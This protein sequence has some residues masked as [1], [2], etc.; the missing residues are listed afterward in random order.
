MSDNQNESNEPVQSFPDPTQQAQV[1]VEPQV[2]VEASGE[3]TA[4]TQEIPTPTVAEASVTPAPTVEP[5][6][7]G[8]IPAGPT[9]S[10]GLAIASL[11]L[12]IVGLL[13]GCCTGVVGLPFA[14]AALITGIIGMKKV[15]AET[16]GKG[17][18]IAGIVLGVIG[19]LIGIVMIIFIAA[20]GAGSFT[21][22]MSEMEMYN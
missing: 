20:I 19:I 3:Y 22:I 1:P 21:E 12:G 8:S 13:F 4:P 16:G 5:A 11:V 2:V 18:A 7:T 14:I 6:P 17:L 10:N 15:D 9:K